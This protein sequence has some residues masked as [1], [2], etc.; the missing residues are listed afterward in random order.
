MVAEPEETS[1]AQRGYF[2]WDVH[3]QAAI[4]AVPDSNGVVDGCRDPIALW[5]ILGCYHP[6]VVVE[7][8][9]SFASGNVPDGCPVIRRSIGAITRVLYEH[10]NPCKDVK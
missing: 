1:V 9:Y 10:I 4:V 7:C 3:E 6:I 5:R 8:L 2:Y